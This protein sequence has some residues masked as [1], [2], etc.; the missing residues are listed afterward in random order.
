[1]QALAYLNTQEKEWQ[2]MREVLVQSHVS[3]AGVMDTQLISSQKLMHVGGGH[4]EHSSR[5]IGSQASFLL[6]A[7]ES[8]TGSPLPESDCRKCLTSLRNEE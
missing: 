7:K 4:C 8:D 3:A 5:L 6:I 2:G 1:M